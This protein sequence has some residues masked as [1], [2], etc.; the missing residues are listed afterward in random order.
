MGWN[1]VASSEKTRKLA[2]KFAHLIQPKV[3]FP[4]VRRITATSIVLLTVLLGG[5]IAPTGVCALMCVRHYRAESP[6]HCN[7]SNGMPGMVHD[8]S[9]MNHPRIKSMSPVLVSQSCQPNCSTAERVNVSRNI[10][11]QLTIVQSGALFLDTTAEFLAPNPAAAW[12]MDNGPPSSPSAYAA[13]FSILR[14]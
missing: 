8:H 7:H 14:I 13:S 1:S 2:R 5:T 9:T 3:Q 11:P 6:S 12:S 4:K 10:V